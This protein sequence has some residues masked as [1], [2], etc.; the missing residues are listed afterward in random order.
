MK[1]ILPIKILEKIISK[2]KAK[3]KKVVLCHGVFDLLHIGHINHF[4]EA[5]FFGDVLVV[6][7]TSDLFVNKGQ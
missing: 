2:L 7:L 6:S 1:K 4:K 3:G 5:K